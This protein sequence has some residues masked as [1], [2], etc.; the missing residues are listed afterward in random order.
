VTDQVQ[1][2][3]YYDGE[4]L[5]SYDFTDEQAYHIEMRRRLNLKLH[6]CGIVHGLQLVEDQDSVKPDAVFYSIAPGMAIDQ[7]GREIYVPAPYSLSAE[8]ILKRAG[9]KTG[10]NELWICYQE[11][12]TGLPAA[13]YRDCNAKDQQTRWQ[14]S[15]QVVLKPLQSAS[16]SFIPP[17]CGGVRLGTVTLDDTNGWHVKDVDNHQG[18]VYVGIRA[19]SVVAPN[20]VDTDNFE[21]TTPHVDATMSIDK[22]IAPPGYVDIRPSIFARGN[23]IIENNVVIGD[24]FELKKNTDQ[25]NLP[26]AANIPKRGNLKV[27]SDLFLKGEFFG[28]LDGK[29]YGLKQYI[30][31]LMPDV[32]AKSV[33]ISIALGPSSSTTNMF[34]VTVKTELPSFKFPPQVMVA[35]QSVQWQPQG[36]LDKW[37][38]TAGATESMELSLVAVPYVVDAQTIELRITWTIGPA[39]QVDATPP[40]TLPVTQ[41]TVGYVVIFQQ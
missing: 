26:D 23:A 28:F 4:Y 22:R 11:T 35:V 17:D 32:K 21:M 20:E 27:T 5:R 41:L 33:D 2:L 12:Q 1:R 16:T 19:Q 8:N 14:E 36:K 24:D 31:S 9:L 38:K 7:T 25:P 37:F 15:F 39:V 3:R 30:Q 10:D 18:R 40:K 13:G 6:L 34:P 29:W